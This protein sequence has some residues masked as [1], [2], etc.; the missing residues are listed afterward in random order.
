MIDRLISI[1]V[2]VGTVFFAMFVIGTIVSF[3]TFIILDLPSRFA[4]EF[5]SGFLIGS[6]AMLA[7]VLLL[8]RRK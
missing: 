4:L 5:T 7:L 8:L 1:L 2:D 6:F 3:A